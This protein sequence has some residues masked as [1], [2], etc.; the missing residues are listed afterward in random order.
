MA[1]AFLIVN[2]VLIAITCLDRVDLID[3]SDHGMIFL[4]KEQFLRFMQES[5][6]IVIQ[7]IDLFLK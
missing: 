5:L 1:L 7:L 2:F 4:Q 3:E 6:R